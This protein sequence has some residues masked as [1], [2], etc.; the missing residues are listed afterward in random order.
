[1][2]TIHKTVCVYKEEGAQKEETF[3]FYFSLAGS[4]YEQYG[5]FKDEDE[6]RGTCVSIDKY[7]QSEW[8]SVKSTR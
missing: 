7:K 4:N 2:S 1:M 5:V 8:L 6:E 3:D